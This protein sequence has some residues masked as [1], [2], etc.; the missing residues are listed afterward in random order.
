MPAAIKEVDQSESRRFF[1]WNSSLSISPLAKRSYK[2]SK[3]RFLPPAN[4]REELV[5]PWSDRIT[6]AATTTRTTSQIIITIGPKTIPY[7]IISPGCI[8]VSAPNGFS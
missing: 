3:S 8:C 5:P 7:H 2:I 4:G 6:A 1:S